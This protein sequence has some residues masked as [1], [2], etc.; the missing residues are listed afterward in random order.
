MLVCMSGHGPMGRLPLMAQRPAPVLISYL[1]CPTTTG[2]KAIGHRIT[3]PLLEGPESRSVEKPLKLDACCFAYEPPAEAP[4]VSPT[5]GDPVTFGCFGAAQKISEPVLD[6]WAA[7]LKQVPDARLLLKHASYDAP[8]ARSAMLKELTDRGIDAG[9]ITIEGHTAAFPDHLGAYGRVDVALDTFP[10]NGMAT[11]CE[12]LWMGVPV[13]SRS[14]TTHASRVGLSLLTAAGLGE[15]VADS[16]DAYVRKAAG[17]AGDT[18]R[19]SSLRTS[20]REKL[21]ASP[22]CDG[23]ALA[24]RLEAQYRTLWKAWCSSV[25]YPEA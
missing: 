20:L 4:E 3:D 9:R 25:Y 11:T 10:Y 7:I 19:R 15:F 13:V 16:Q 6:A 17:L 8:S 24:A 21:K 12:A 1:G 18:T 22:L 23:A 2:L 5:A 14:G